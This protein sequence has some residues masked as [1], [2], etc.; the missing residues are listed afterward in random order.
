MLPA[1][2]KQIHIFPES[3]LNGAYYPANNIK[4]SI[5]RWFDNEF[6]NQKEKYIK[7][8]LGFRSYL[9][10]T[11]N[12]MAY[13]LYNMP[14]T[15]NAV[16]GKDN[17]LYIN[18][19]IYNYTGENY[20]GDK[21]INSISSK[22]KTLQDFLSSKNIA[23]ITAFLPSK[24]SFYPEYIPDTFKDFPKKNQSA[25]MASFDRLD[26][27]Y[28]D[29]NAYFQQIKDTCEIPL[30]PKNGLHWTSYGMALGIDSIIKTIAHYTHKTLQN[31]KWETPVFMDK[32]NRLPDYD[33]ENLLNLF[34]DLKRSPKPYPKFIFDN[35]THYD[36]PK[37]LVIT[38]SYYWQ[39]YTAH[40]PHHIFDWGGF[41]YYFKTLR[42]ND[43]KK[44]H[45]MDA[46]DINIQEEILKQDVVVLLASQATL[47]LYPFGF[48]TEGYDELIFHDY[49]AT[50]EYFRK[51]ITNNPKW[52]KT[53]KEK[54][55]QNHFTAE[56]QLHSD[57]IY[58]AR[59]YLKKHHPDALEKFNLIESIQSNPKWMDKIEKKAITNKIS[60]KQQLDKDAEWMLKHQKK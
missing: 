50:T 53:I 56:Q 46:K 2:Q 11:N 35:K 10:R 5:H 26:I 27:N 16:I 54:A 40:I 51:L 9:I 32:T 44:E 45:K 43:G 7:D 28:I 47:H 19:Y 57:I 59:K 20:I 37:T 58:T 17:Y 4:L 29:L 22:I 31:L 60:T 41:W 23:L 13:S 52:M 33:A 18:S 25:F 24:A 38:D 48:E 39:A 3:T 55:S 49:N 36:K 12:Q 30:F 34:F 6:Q 8:H 1:L 14:Q 42:Y 21:K 15:P